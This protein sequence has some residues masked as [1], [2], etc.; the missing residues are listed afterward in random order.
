MVRGSTRTAIRVLNLSQTGIKGECNAQ[1][2][3]GE[4]L[5][6]SLDNAEPVPATALWVRGR[7]FGA[8]FAAALPFEMLWPPIAGRRAMVAGQSGTD[9]IVVEAMAVVRCEGVA[10]NVCIRNVSLR[11]LL[12]ETA[13]QLKPTQ[14][15][16]IDVDG[17]PPLKGAIVWSRDGHV[18]V[19][20]KHPLTE[21]QMLSLKVPRR[22]PSP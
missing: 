17:W 6:I 22:A 3:F 20:L 8:E 19:H 18:G 16:E 9:R 7:R 12:I 4:C 1:L 14:V 10:M 13:A 15:V 21:E 2:S 11:G 5:N